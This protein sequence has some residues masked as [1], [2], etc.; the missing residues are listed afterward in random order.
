MRQHKNAPILSTGAE[1]H[2]AEYMYSI[3]LCKH[4]ILN[5]C[6]ATDLYIATKLNIIGKSIMSMTLAMIYAQW[7]EVNERY[8]KRK[9]LYLKVLILLED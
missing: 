2:G 4:R 8:S 5:V 9:K 3:N 1:E 7:S 6:T